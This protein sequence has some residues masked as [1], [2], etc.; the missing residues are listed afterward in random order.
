MVKN[1]YEYIKELI[2]E[3]GS[4]FF[5]IENHSVRNDISLYQ[6]ADLLCGTAC[7]FAT[8]VVA[9]SWKV[10]E[11]WEYA[12]P[13]MGI[14]FVKPNGEER[15][16]HFSREA[17]VGAICIVAIRNGI[18]FDDEDHEKLRELWVHKLEGKQTDAEKRYFGEFEF[19]CMNFDDRFYMEKRSS[20]N[21]VVAVKNGEA[22]EY[23]KTKFTLEDFDRMREEERERKKHEEEERIWYEKYS[24]ERDERKREMER[25]FG[26][27]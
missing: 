6:L 16:I 17:F 9:Y 20:E 13:V 15:W 19:G 14:M 3:K 11:L 12:F 5:N 10:P 26:K 23:E 1:F 21:R 4:V 18:T 24:R 22:N 2:P 27:K 25:L 7:H 8:D